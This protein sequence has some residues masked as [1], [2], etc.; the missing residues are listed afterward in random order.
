MLISQAVIVSSV[1]AVVWLALIVVLVKRRKMGKTAAL[2][3][4]LLPLLAGNLYYYRWV[5]PQQQQTARLAAAQQKLATMPVWGTVKIQQ[6]ALYRQASEEL[7]R[8]LQNGV[9]EQQAFDRL[10]PLAA[11]LLNQRIN[12]AADE[13]LIRYMQVSLEQMKLLRQ[14]NPDLCFRFLFPQIRGGV[15]IGEVLPRS[16]VDKEMQAMDTLL[17]N[18]RGAERATDIQRGRSRMQSVVR[19]LYDRWGIDLQNL[20]APAEPGVDESKLCDMT[21]DLYQSVLA[22][23]DKDSASVLRIMISGTG[24]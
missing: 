11:D 21:I 18:S 6:P 12:A 17:K 15:N 8:S 23:T 13:D 3:L 9:A 24:N 19:K 22:L 10:R 5:A 16:A 20:N 1:T 7:Q 14:K 4:L 2:L